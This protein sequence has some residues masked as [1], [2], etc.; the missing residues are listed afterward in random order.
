MTNRKATE[1]FDGYTHGT[2]INK[3]FWIAGSHDNSDFKEMIEEMQ[4]SDWKDCLPEIRKSKSY[5]EYQKD[6]EMGQALVDH[7]K[8]GLIAEL[9]HPRC[10]DFRYNDKGEIWSSSVSMGNCRISYVYAEDLK[11]LMSAIEKSADKIYKEYVEKDKKKPVAA[12]AV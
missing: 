4:D 3:L 11:E 6:N 12:K 2:F 9:H 7:N 5:K 8:F 10:Y 1:R